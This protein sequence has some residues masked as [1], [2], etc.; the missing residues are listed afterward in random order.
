MNQCFLPESQR[1]SYEWLSSFKPNYHSLNV[2]PTYSHLDLFMGVKAATD[3]F[4]KMI[5]ALDGP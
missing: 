5:A 1:R 3:V 4:P 2:L